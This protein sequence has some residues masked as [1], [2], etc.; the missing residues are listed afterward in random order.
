MI[1]GASHIGWRHFTIGTAIGLAP[2]ILAINLFKTQAERAVREPG[3]GS[4]LLLVG[5]LVLIVLGIA[6]ARRTFKSLAEDED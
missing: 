4:V 2:G 6:W 5:V 3:A 1:A